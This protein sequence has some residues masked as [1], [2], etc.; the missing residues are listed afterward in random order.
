[1]VYR[2]GKVA[3]VDL[4]GA[5]ILQVV[6]DSSTGIVNALQFNKSTITLEEAD[7]PQIET[8]NGQNVVGSVAKSLSKVTFSDGKMDQFHFTVD[9]KVQPRL[10]IGS[11]G[12]NSRTLGWNAATSLITQDNDWNYQISPSVNGQTADFSRKSVSGQ[13]EAWSN[14]PSKGQEV[15][16]VNGV[17][18]TTSRF[19]S[20]KLSGLI[21]KITETT[22]GTEKVVYTADYDEQGR[23]IRVQDKDKTRTYIYD[24]ANHSVAVYLDGKLR[25]TGTYDE[26]R[27]L[28]S[29]VA[30]DGLK[31][32]ITYLPDGTPKETDTLP[33]GTI[34]IR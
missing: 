12:A 16:E 10:A 8:I 25:S 1:M 20:G 19:A 5:P 3:E 9:D 21:R 28:I 6:T 23:T 24:D 32:V 11:P 14:D 26:Q 33:N 22:G 34:V 31:R 4:N 13:S 2:E 15:T 7:K 30:T 17:K 18:R 29:S 27:R